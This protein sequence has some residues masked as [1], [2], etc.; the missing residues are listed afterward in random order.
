MQMLEPRVVHDAR[1]LAMAEK[2][3]VGRQETRG[4]ETDGPQEGAQEQSR[5]QR[6]QQTQEVA[7]PGVE[8]SALMR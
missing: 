5:T 1:P 8:P 7:S 6:R 4:E 3:F 2:Q